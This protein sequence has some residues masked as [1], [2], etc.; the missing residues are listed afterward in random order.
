MKT[1]KKKTTIQISIETKNCLVSIKQHPLEPYEDT[2]RRLINLYKLVE[3]YY[4]AKAEEKKRLTE[5]L[6]KAE[7]TASEG[8][9]N[10]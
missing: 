1:K 3:S 9:H 5:E 2:I 10:D 8:E 6:E 4:I 7:K